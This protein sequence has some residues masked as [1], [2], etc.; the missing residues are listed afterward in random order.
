MLWPHYLRMIPSLTVL[1]LIPDNKKLQG[2][3]V[4]KKGCPFSPNLSILTI[5]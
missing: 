5:D 4:V 2:G 3:Q 1:E